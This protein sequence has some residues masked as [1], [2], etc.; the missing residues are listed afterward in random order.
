MTDLIDPENDPAAEDNNGVLATVFDAIGTHFGHIP[1]IVRKNV[2]KAFN[3]LMKVPNAYID[4]KAAE[5]KATSDARVAVTKATG[6]TLAQS[7]EVD[8]SLAAIATATNASRI[9]RQ[10]VNAAKVLQYAAV[11]VKQEA[12]TDVATE[13]E[14]ISED[15]LNAFEREAVDMSSEHMQRL[16][17]KILAGEMKRPK[18]YSIRTV[19]LMAQLDNHAAGLF[20]VL[21]S[22]A[23]TL[24][25]G[26]T[27]ADA[28][29]L[30]LGQPAGQN[31]LQNFGLGFSEL[32]ILFEYGLIINDFGSVMGY[33][34]SVVQHHTVP[35]P[36]R[37]ANRR[38]GLLSKNGTAV[39]PEQLTSFRLSGVQL[40][41]AGKELLGIVDLVESTAYTAELTKFFDSRGYA[42]IDVA[43]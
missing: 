16:F 43:N 36:I 35:V 32:N 25:I 24:Q 41:Q 30:D 40:S 5:I 39:T 31:G 19:K 12:S 34:A 28:R 10:Q 9:L 15:W 6:K 33:G 2:A 17:G 13:P 29:V 18:S 22:M 1:A 26:P 14:E 7:I 11:E 3:H 42:L 37:Y 8:K 4:G 20:R 21:C 27:V 23:C 38:F